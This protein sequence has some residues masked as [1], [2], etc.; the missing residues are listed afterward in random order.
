MC[1]KWKILHKADL[2]HIHKAGLYLWAS[3]QISVIVWIY[4][5]APQHDAVRYQALWYQT[6]DSAKHYDV[7]Q[8]AKT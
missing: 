4:A 7:I 8:Y 5:D 2:Y 1:V 3:Q 6:L